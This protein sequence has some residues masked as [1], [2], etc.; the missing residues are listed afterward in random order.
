MAETL[1]FM[2][3]EKYN[4][5]GGV[6]TA[7][8]AQ[9]QQALGNLGVS[10]YSSYVPPNPITPIPSVNL[11]TP[12]LNLPIGTPP[13]N[14]SSLVA[15]VIAGQ[16]AS[17][18]PPPSD[19][20]ALDKATTDYNSS[21]QTYKGLIE[22]TPD[23]SKIYNDVANAAGL[24]GQ[25]SQIDQLKTELAS[26]SASYNNQYQNIGAQGV[27]KG[28]PAVF[29]QG[30]QAAQQRQASVVLSGKAA[31]LAALQGNFNE[32][33]S[34]A[35]QT[36]SMM[37]QARE[38]KIKNAYDFVKLNQDT[39]T[40]AQANTI[41]ANAATEKVEL[42]A[43]KSNVKTA[44]SSGVETT[45]WTKP[46]GTVV[47][48]NDGKEYSTPQEAFADGVL[49]DF[50]NA[51]KIQPVGKSET[52]KLNGVTY[53]IVYD[54]AGNVLSKTAL[55]GGTPTTSSGIPVGADPK[56][57]ADV[58][59]I[60]AANPGEYGNAADAINAKYPGQAAKY[61]VLLKT[62]YLIPADAANVINLSGPPP[63]AEAWAAGRQKFINDHAYN[64]TAAATAYDKFV[65]K[66]TKSSGS[67]AITNPFA[68]K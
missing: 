40:K 44:L 65:K 37:F 33:Q 67:S 25:K 53:H 31:V 7:A 64:P 45:F 2:S 8:N 43:Q 63:T 12:N 30:E 57:A 62:T 36:A 4:V 20:A 60:I 68:P 3:G 48:T 50:S 39:L 22:D 34:L 5:S 42:E 18:P 17:M 35:E 58:K 61:D 59:K 23:E 38:N 49:P 32:A 24:P 66:P 14:G 26:L 47:R 27:E 21:L 46:N 9:A 15:G 13:N 56:Q 19:T 11:T 28:V 29:Y 6:A 10:S 41:K 52:K 51:P 54:Q 16:N 55:D 1:G